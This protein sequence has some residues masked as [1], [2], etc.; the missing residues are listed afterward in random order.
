MSQ[1][2]TQ[3]PA[4]S[5]GEARVLGLSVLVLAA[6]AA[7]NAGVARYGVVAV[8][9]LWLQALWLGLGLLLLVRGLA[10]GASEGIPG[11]RYGPGEMAVVAAVTAAALAVRVWQLDALR[12]LIDEG[13]SIENLFHARAPR[14]ALLLPPSQYISTALYPYWNSLV[15]AATGPGL[16]GLRLASAVI[17]ALT[18]PAL[19]LLARAA[20]DRTTAL[21]AAILLAALPAHLHF[22]RVAL[23]H[24]M[25][26][27][28]GTLALAGVVRGLAG[29]GRLA[30]AGAGVAL[31]LTHYGFEAGRWF[32]TPLVALW[33]ALHAAFKPGHLCGFR[34]ELTVLVTAFAATVTPLY[35]AALASGSHLTPRLQASGLEPA[36]LAQLLTDPLAL[37]RR[38]WFA[39]G[40]YGW[41]V[42][43]TQFYGGDQALI[44]PLLVWFALLGVL[45]A[46]ARPRD[47][48]IIVPLWLA[49]AW[50]A[51]AAMRDSAAYA[52]WVVALPAVAL[53]AAVG[54]CS[55]AAWCPRRGAAAAVA[56]VI[57][58]AVV[59]TRYYF[60][61]HIGRL[62]EQARAAKPYRDACDAALRAADM[63]RHGAVVI[64]SD[65]VVD[66]HPPRSL[67]RLLRDGSEP[68]RLDA[69]SP[70]EFDG[71][72]LAALPADAD[73]AFFL[74][75]DDA[76]TAARLRECFELEDAR[77]SPQVLA[78]DK[79]LI[80]YLAPA[81][82]RRRSCGAARP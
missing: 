21:C 28:F 74:A 40:V 32:Y 68:I 63:L 4:V 48:G 59:Q 56:A 61:T 71:T 46:L 73:L 45:V 10:A 20:F 5:R 29:A 50:L 24:V 37:G 33:L 76:L 77:A 23:P 72:K 70:D 41:N 82:S 43:Q 75:P 53:A 80:L 35:G 57:A 60:H 27:L 8:V 81:G 79:E 22:S 58:L 69:Y 1:C 42:D 30:W 19:W 49:A 66:V 9:P 67:L 78:R 47:P 34:R 18:V 55:L 2:Q 7:E 62:A 44:P 12:V 3:Q 26:A 14:A 16:G 31:G 65:P 39:A 15:V 6:L 64:V 38:L 54:V 11:R 51:N 25:D 52:R 36:Q 17:G 13:N